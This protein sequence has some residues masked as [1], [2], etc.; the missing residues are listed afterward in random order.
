[1]AHP[2]KFVGDPESHW[3]STYPQHGPIFGPRWPILGPSWGQIWSSWVQKSALGESWSPRAP[4]SLPEPL[5]A[6]KQ[7]QST[8]LPGS[9]LEGFWSHVGFQEP[10][11]GHS[12]SIQNF[13][14]FRYPFFMDFALILEASWEGLGSHLCFQDA[15]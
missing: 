3:G 2:E 15:L 9:V 4:K 5:Q 1:M 8:P 7:E 10:L 12:K 6:Q 11:K 14:R 13:D